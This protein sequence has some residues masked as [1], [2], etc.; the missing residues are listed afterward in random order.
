MTN[1][2]IHHGS[3]GL[4]HWASVPLALAV[5]ASLSSIA[6][7]GPAATLVAMYAPL[8]VAVMLLAVVIV[9]ERMPEAERSRAGLPQSLLLSIGAAL[10][11][12]TMVGCAFAGRG[13]FVD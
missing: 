2:R 3:A 10:V 7:G 9:R 6:P 12:G 5:A 11:G 4:L 8:F 1:D 13:I